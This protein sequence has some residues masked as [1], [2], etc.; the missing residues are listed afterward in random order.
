[1][2]PS[3]P[4]WMDRL[5]RA[6]HQRHGDC[7]LIETHISWVLLSG[8]QVYK[9][10]KPVDL[11]FLDFSSQ[12]KRRHFCREEIRLNRR[13]APEFYLG[14]EEIRANGA[15]VLPGGPGELLDYAVHMRRFPESRTLADRPRQLTRRHAAELAL[16]LEQFHRHAA[17]ANPDDGFGGGEQVI[18]PMRDN[19]QVISSLL[20]PGNR[21][22]ER[23]REWTE[24]SHLQLLPHLQQ[25]LDQGFIREC[26][27]DLHLGN[28]TLVDDHPLVFDA[29]E[30]SPSL[31][32][33][34][35]QSELAFLL[36]DLQRHGRNDLVGPLFNDYLAASGDYGGVVLQPF[37]RL[38]RLLV[39]LKVE[40]IAARQQAVDSSGLDELAARFWPQ[41]MS[42]REP[43]GRSLL[44]CHGLSGSG[45]SWQARA[46]CEQL[47]LIHLRSDV[48]RK[49]LAGLAAGAR[50]GSGADGGIYTSARTDATY[51]RLLELSRQLLLD[52]WPVLVDATFL[53]R[54]RR[55]AFRA[56]AREL[57]APF[58]IL[59]FDLP[60]ELLQQRV[61]ERQE[62]GDDPSEASLSVLQRQLER[63]QPLDE[64]EREVAVDAAIDADALAACLQR[65]LGVCRDS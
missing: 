33:I 57:D 40:V 28:I 14:V 24:Q 5:C 36:M 15:E 29:I 48:E 62:R 38:Y 30:F 4:A 63:D 13:L 42:Y 19:F 46:L 59:E 32:W 3:Q 21:I 12:E 55:L 8:D 45:K 60:Q 51:A 37:Y 22:L 16:Q 49:R 44:I 11:G 17:V 53:D 41:A 50:S 65:L 9:I 52:D 35:V 7:R 25:R 43:P 6:L 20:S 2:S 23:L 39:R 1:M 10:K 18:G 56:L 27:G 47:P 34:D 64:A 26:H 61:R 54:D 58:L 31:R